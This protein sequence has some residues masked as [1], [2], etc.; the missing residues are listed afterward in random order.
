MIDRPQGP[1]WYRTR[2]A[3]ARRGEDHTDTALGPSP[4]IR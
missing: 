3:F 2:E 1:G 4:Y